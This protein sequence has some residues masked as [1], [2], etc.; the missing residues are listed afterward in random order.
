[1]PPSEQLSLASDM[2]GL[3][4][5]FYMEPKF[6]LVFVLMAVAIFGIV[7]IVKQMLAVVPPRKDGVA[8]LDFWVVKA[9]MHALPLLLGVLIAVMPGVFAEYPAVVQ[10]LIGV[11]AGYLSD[12]VYAL[13][14]RRLPNLLMSSAAVRRTTDSGS[15]SDSEAEGK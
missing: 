13:L 6:W 15:S 11:C 3:D 12:K 10:V 9:A 1:M 5:G 8:W 14:K 4:L 2:T 7:T